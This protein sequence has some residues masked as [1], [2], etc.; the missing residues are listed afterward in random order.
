M[1]H[2][3]LPVSGWNQA[4]ASGTSDKG[5]TAVDGSNAAQ[6]TSSSTWK[7]FFVPEGKQFN[8]ANIRIGD[9]RP[10]NTDPESVYEN[11][12]W[13]HINPDVYTDATILAFNVSGKSAGV[14]KEAG[15]SLGFFKSTTDGKYVVLWARE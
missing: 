11:F 1:A 10:T 12:L 9:A 7:E 3:A 8:S 14:A 5:L 2:K 4:I 6:T 15:E 13:C